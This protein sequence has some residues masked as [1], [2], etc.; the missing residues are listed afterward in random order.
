MKPREAFLTA[1]FFFTANRLFGMQVPQSPDRP[2]K[3]HFVRTLFVVSIFL[4]VGIIARNNRHFVHR[5]KSPAPSVMS[6]GQAS[7]SSVPRPI[8]VVETPEQAPAW[9]VPFGKE[10]WRRPSK[11]ATTPAKSSAPDLP[12]SINLGDLMDRVTFAFRDENKTPCVNGPTY[13][14]EAASSGIRFAPFRPDETREDARPFNDGVTAILRTKQIRAS[15]ATI[16]PPRQAEHVVAG[17]TVQRLLNSAGFV[18]HFESTEQGLSVSWII[19][20]KPASGDLTV[21]FEVAGL[22]YLDR[23]EQ[24]HHF[25]DGS[26]TARLCVGKAT[27]VDSSNAKWDLTT[28]FANGALQITV[29]ANLLAR[30]QYPI[31]IDPAVMPEFGIDNYIVPSAPS[32]FVPAVAHTSGQ[33]L[34]VWDNPTNII[35][36]R[37]SEA[38]ELLDLGGI[39]MSNDPS[40]HRFPNVAGTPGGYLVV[41]VD[42][43]S[44]TANG[45]DIYGTHVSTAGAVLNPN[46]IAIA[47]TTALENLPDVANNGNESLVVWQSNIQIFGARVRSDGVVLDSPGVQLSSTGSQIFP[48]VACSG[49]DYLAVWQHTPSG[50]TATDIRGARVSLANVPG[51]EFTISAATNNERTPAVASIGSDYLVVWEDNRIGPD[52]DVFGARVTAAGVGA[53]IEVSRVVGGQFAPAITASANN[54]FVVW[55]DSR[56]FTTQKFDVYGARVDASG[57]VLD[58]GGFQITTSPD[59]ETAPAVAAGAGNYLVAW[60]EELKG[61]IRATFVSFGAGVGDHNGMLLTRAFPTQFSPAIA[62]NGA[63]F[64]VAWTD[65]RNSIGFESNIVFGAR[66]NSTGQLLGSSGLLISRAASYKQAIDVAG[67]A[68]QFLVVWEDRRADGINGDIFGCRVAGGVVR[69]TN[70]IPITTAAG[71]QTSPAVA[72]DGTDFMAVWDSG[73]VILGSRVAQNGTVTDPGGI[74]IGGGGFPDVAFG[75]GNYFVVWHDNQP[76]R[77]IRGARVNNGTVLDPSGIAINSTP[78]TLQRYPRIAFNGTH[79][80]VVWQDERNSATTFTDIYSTLVDTA[81][82][83]LSATGVNL[84]GASY[85]R[86]PAVAAGPPDFLVIW[87][88]ASNSASTGIDI[89]GGRVRGGTGAAADGTGFTI[90]NAPGDPIGYAV[91]YAGGGNYLVVY[92]T[93]INGV[94]RIM[95]RFVSGP[96]PG[97]PPVPGLFNTGVDNLGRAL[98][99]NAQ[100]PHYMAA[101]NG[102]IV[103]AYAATSAQGFPIPPWIA[104]SS[105]SA[106]ISPTTNTIAVGGVRF[107]FSYTTTFDLSGYDPATAVI[108]GQWATDNEGIDILINGQS[109]GQRNT[110]QFTSYTPFRISS[111]FIR[112]GNTLTFIVNNADGPGNNP[113]GLRVEMDGTAAFL[114]SPIIAPPVWQKGKVTLTWEGRPGWQYI[115]E[116]NDD[117]RLDPRGWREL[118]RVRAETAIVTYTDSTADGHSQRIYRILA[119]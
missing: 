22:K 54:Y 94:R 52:P 90:Q 11:P 44:N 32:E 45:T 12:P 89:A 84:T 65:Y 7:L 36:A 83:V 80:L 60:Q 40:I 34:V 57:T 119:R 64:L 24:G 47:T 99:D 87:N 97:N 102:I 10:F 6:S 77:H 25:A 110:A 107:S 41:W 75:G 46:G 42:Y 58:P 115:I 73:G 29:P 1:R 27:L 101:I 33:F 4:T 81:G 30:A 17:N 71:H 79:F 106:W 31:A 13:R 72:T 118:A 66:L 3:T 82:T 55:Q 67:N 59:R 68:N 62:F 16:S 100:D 76:L 19:P 112:G 23:T 111:G 103:P 28:E 9:A 14:A 37:I 18:E 70:G 113:T 38:G 43:R 86:F 88:D 92:D 20:Q 5:A 8:Q 2:M 109:T 56:F 48:A 117:P 85:Q 63:E 95:G 78:S 108:V 15:G 114:S 21:D 39:A 116:Y 53:P 104:D 105:V 51:A 50:Q 96:P 26:G 35:G 74:T 91:D 49:A 61:D 69:D 98:A 93:L